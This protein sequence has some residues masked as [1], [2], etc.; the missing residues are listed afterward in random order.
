[1]K[2]KPELN[3]SATESRPKGTA[4]EIQ[5]WCLKDIAVKDEDDD[6]W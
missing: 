5:M 2:K 4:V 6:T 1:M 3:P